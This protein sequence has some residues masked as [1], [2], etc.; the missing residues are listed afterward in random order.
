MTATLIP[1]RTSLS[2]LVTALARVTRRRDHRAGL[3]A[4]LETARLVPAV[5]V[6]GIQHQAAEAIVRVGLP[7]V[8]HRRRMVQRRIDEHLFLDV[9]GRAGVRVL[10]CWDEQAHRVR[11][12][13]AETG[14]P[15][16]WDRI[17]VRFTEW[18]RDG[19]PVPGA[20]EAR[21]AGS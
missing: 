3:L 14:E 20:D 12:H 1:P 13:V 6:P 17:V 19:R 4:E 2:G 16:L 18:E 15:G 10:A 8:E 9:D 11:M 21:G 5:V 7:A